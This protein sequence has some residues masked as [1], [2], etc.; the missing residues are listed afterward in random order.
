MDE[1]TRD[2]SL[3]E[4]EHNLSSLIMKEKVEEE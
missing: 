4:Q 3:A 1:L 2:F